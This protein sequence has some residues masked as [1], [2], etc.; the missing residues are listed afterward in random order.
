MAMPQTCPFARYAFLFAPDLASSNCTISADFPRS[1]A[2]AIA[3]PMVS[4]ARR[5]GSASRWA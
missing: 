3:E 5:N 4:T 1:I 2:P